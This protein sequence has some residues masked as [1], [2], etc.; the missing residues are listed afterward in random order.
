MKVLWEERAWA[1]Y[2]Y[3]QMQD[4]KTL[5]RINELGDRRTLEESG[6]GFSATANLESVFNFFGSS[7][8]QG[9]RR[10]FYLR[11]LTEAGGMQFPREQA[12]M[13]ASV[14]EYQ[15]LYQ[16]LE[17]NFLR[18]PP[19][20]MQLNELLRVLEAI[21]S[22]VPSSTARAEATDISLYDHVRLTA[23]YAASMVQYFKAHGITDYKKHTT[24][25][26]H[27]GGRDEGVGEVRGADLFR[28]S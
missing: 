25:T 1:D 28:L 21:L 5:K 24:G 19:S 26:R 27:G 23:A 20:D 3:W 4:R 10:A 17:A 16:H 15:E 6:G 11:G 9:G 7:S 8:S 22:Y 13:R 18:R 12:D 14:A 2:L